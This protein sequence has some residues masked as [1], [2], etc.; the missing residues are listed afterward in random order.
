M[1]GMTPS[2][3]LLFL[4]STGMYFDR[5]SSNPTVLSSP[6]KMAPTHTPNPSQ[7]WVGGVSKPL[8]GNGRGNRLM[9]RRLFISSSTI[10]PTPTLAMQR[11]SKAIF[12]KPILPPQS[13]EPVSRAPFALHSHSKKNHRFPIPPNS[14]FTPQGPNNKTLLY[15]RDL[16]S[17]SFLVPAT[18]HK[19]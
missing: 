11:C 3:P 19:K 10:T 12:L 4:S 1:K 5:R 16:F 14:P 17:S 18:N 2:L 13:R 8:E 9:T 6:A 15:R 7:C